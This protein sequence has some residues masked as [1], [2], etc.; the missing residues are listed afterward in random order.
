MSELR[1]S[2]NN[3]CDVCGSVTTHVLSIVPHPSDEDKRTID[4]HWCTCCDSFPEK[5]V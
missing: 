1:N 4:V 5:R 2:E 3:E